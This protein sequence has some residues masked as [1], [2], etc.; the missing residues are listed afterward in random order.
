MRR[1]TL[2]VGGIAV[3]V[4][5]FIAVWT[6]IQLSMRNCCTPPPSPQSMT[7]PPEVRANLT[8]FPRAT[9]LTG[10]EADALNVLAAQVTACADYD[11]SR[12]LQMLQHIAWLIDPAQIPPQLLPAFGGNVTERLLFGMATFTRNMWR[13]VGESPDSC[14][15]PIG[16]AVNLRLVAAGGTAEAA[17]E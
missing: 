10:A 17:F 6:A 11:E 12:R 2:I 1:R 8:A 16:R 5:V 4:L 13:A 15:L 3:L 9:P 7:L 14:L